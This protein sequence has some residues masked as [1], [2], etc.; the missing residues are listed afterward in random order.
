MSGTMEEMKKVICSF[1]ENYDVKY[2]SKDYDS[3]RNPKY[4]NSKEVRIYLELGLKD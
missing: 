1:E 4:K 3:S 2:V